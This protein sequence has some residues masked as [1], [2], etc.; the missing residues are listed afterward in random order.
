MVMRSIPPSGPRSCQADSTNVR[1]GLR[2]PVVDQPE[3]RAPVVGARDRRGPSGRP[4]VRVAVG[5]GALRGHGGGDA[6]PA[7]GLGAHRFS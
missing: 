7:G 1:V 6:C 3:R 4:L 5:A 2:D